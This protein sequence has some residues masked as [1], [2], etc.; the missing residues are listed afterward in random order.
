MRDEMRMGLM[1]GWG[2]EEDTANNDLKA[3][4]VFLKQERKRTHA[5]EVLFCFRNQLTKLEK[6]ACRV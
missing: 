1:M 2:I 6:V 3:L 4:D 5:K